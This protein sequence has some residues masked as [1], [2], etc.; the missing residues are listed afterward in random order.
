MIDLHMH[1]LYSDGQFGVTDLLGILNKEGIKYASITDHNSLDSHIEIRDN[2]LEELYD[3]KMITGVEL[4]TLVDGYLIEVLI[5]NFDLDSFSEYV[6]NTRI[7][8][9]EFHN[10]AYQKLLKKAQEMGLKYIE[11]KKELQN[12]YYCN[13]KFQDAI[14]ACF[15]YNKK[16]VDEKVLTDHLYFYR[17]EFQNPKSDFFIDNTEAFPSLKEVIEV[18]HSCGGL[19]F[20]AHIDE[21]QAIKDKKSFLEMLVS[22]YE[23]DGIECFHPSICDKNREWYMNYAKDN[24]LLISAGSDFHGIHLPHR[25][26]INTKATLEDVDWIEKIKSRNTSKK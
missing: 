21:Y 8:F 17:N 19:V 2:N 10:K 6:K 26:G 25:K 9:W 1:T 22:N 11:P 12:G 7:K 13:M 16:I 20:L 24:G 4:Q 5:Y 3:G 18:A 15:S 23:L 14:A